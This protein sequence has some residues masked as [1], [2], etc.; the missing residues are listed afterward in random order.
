MWFCEHCLLL[1]RFLRNYSNPSLEVMVILNPLTA[2]LFWKKKYIF[3]IS[4]SRSLLK[5][6]EE[7]F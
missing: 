5:T 4:N 1:S 6:E 7:G 3:E 2:S